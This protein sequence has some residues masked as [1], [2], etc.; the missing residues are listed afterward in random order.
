MFWIDYISEERFS[1]W[2]GPDWCQDFDNLTSAEKFIE[3]MRKD[4]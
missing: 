1:V 2:Y 3:E 4:G